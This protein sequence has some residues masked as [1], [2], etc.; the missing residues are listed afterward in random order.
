MS[1]IKTLNFDIR[2]DGRGDLIAIESGRTLPFEFKRVYYLT[3]LT[4]HPRGF[5]CH[6]HLQQAA[7]CVKGACT[8]ILDNGNLRESVRLDQPNQG[9]LIGNMIWREM[10]D[11]TDDCVLMVLASEHYDE[12]DYI[13]DYNAF[14]ALVKQQDNDD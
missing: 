11:F 13:R 1:L 14:L 12:N 4:A 9:L 8:F 6:K 3:N 2:S 5:H 10:H 7:I